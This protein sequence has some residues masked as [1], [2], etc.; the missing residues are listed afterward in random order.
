MYGD[1][2]LKTWP[3]WLHGLISIFPPHSQIRKLISK[4]SPPQTRISSSYVPRKLKY[5]FWMASKPP[6]IVG[7]SIGLISISG[8]QELRTLA[9]YAAAQVKVIPLNCVLLYKSEILLTQ[10][11]TPFEIAFVLVRPIEKVS[12]SMFSITGVWTR[13][14]SSAIRANI[15]S[16]HRLWHSQWASRNTSTSPFAA[17]APVRRALMSPWRSG[18]RMS[19]TCNGG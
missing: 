2:A 9:V 3:T 8:I 11:K 14:G 7:E 10:S 18:W 1:L 4:F 19:F 16:S 17:A 6:A 5:D 13:V 12:L 15:G